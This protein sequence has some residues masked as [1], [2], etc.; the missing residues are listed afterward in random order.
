MSENA[1]QY[2]EDVYDY[3][4]QSIQI[5]RETSQN[6]T[7]KSVITDDNTSKAIHTAD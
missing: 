7:H 1:S 3:L 4:D 5:N 6:K 2:L